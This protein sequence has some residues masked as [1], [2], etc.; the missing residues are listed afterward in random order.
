LNHKEADRVP[1]HDSPW[2]TT[3]TRWRKEGLPEKVSPADYFGYEFRANSCDNTLQLPI[4]KIEETP[5]YVIATT[6]DGAV[7]K[8]WKG[9]TST[10]ELIDFTITTRA[11]WEEHKPRM[12]MNEKRVDWVNQLKANKTY[13]EMGFFRYMSFGPGFTKVCNMVGPERLLMAIVE[14]PDWVKDMVLTEAK[15]CVAAAEEMMARGFEFDAGWIFDDLGY[16]QH[17]FFS[18]ATYREIFMPAH[19][20][21]CDCFKSRGMKMLLHCCGYAMEFV[22][23]LIECGFDCLQPLEVKAGNDMIGLKKR[24]GDRLAFMGGIDVRAMADPDPNVIE[25]EIRTK[26][27]PVKAGG[28]YIYHSDHSVP[29][30]VSFQQYCR[31]MELVKKYGAYGA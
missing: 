26:I 17:G 10:P 16:K 29:D 18:P 24:F 2:A 6:G 1:I 27:P 22:P 13:T 30:N 23:L 9:A 12:V 5:A 31:V 20:L 3:L 28:G 25:H 15:V 21:I 8:N 11:K 19:K 4:K 7:R 14:D